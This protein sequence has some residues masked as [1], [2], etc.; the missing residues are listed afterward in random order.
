MKD[1]K[2]MKND[3]EYSI[4]AEI[5][6]KED[7][8][9]RELSQKL[10]VSLGSVNVLLN[11]MVGEGLVKVQ[12]VS[13]K[14]VL[15]M[16]TPVGMAEKAK[17]TYQYVKRHYTYI[18]ETKSRIKSYFEDVLEE[19]HTMTLIYIKDHSEIDDLVLAAINELDQGLR[20]R[21]SVR[22]KIEK[23]EGQIDQSVVCVIGE[24]END[25]HYG[26]VVDLM[27]MI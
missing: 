8:S 27:E 4:M 21:I 26:E 15:Y 9:Q 25:W 7:I 1:E 6:E 11:K 17:K 14:Q 19:N 13:S 20:K 2:L 18:N 3:N 23:H 16:L 22:E 12:R 24:K 5:A 10:G